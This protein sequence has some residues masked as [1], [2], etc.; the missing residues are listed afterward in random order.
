MKET[1]HTTKQIGRI[2]R[3]AETSGQSHQVI[4]R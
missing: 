1:H 2:L 4:C 3:E